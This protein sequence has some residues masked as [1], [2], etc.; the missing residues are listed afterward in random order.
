MI[1]DICPRRCHAERTDTSG[2]G[3]C[4]MALT[5]RIARAALHVW[6]EPCISGTRGSGAV[7]FSG[8]NLGCVFCQNFS[9]SH[10]GEGV[11][12]SPERLAG[13]FRELEAL[14]AHNINLVNPTHFV[15]AILKALSLYRPHLPIVYNC[16]GYESV[17]TLRSLEGIVD[18]YLPD[19]KYIDADAARVY[20]DAADYPSVCQA[21]LVE[22]C[23]QTGLPI[24]DD[25]G[26]MTR[27]TLVRHLVLPG[28]AGHSMRVLNWIEENLPKGTPVSLMGQYTPCGEAEKYPGMNRRLKKREYASVLAHMRAIGLT[29]GY[30]QEIAA[31]DRAF[32]PA[33]D[34]TGV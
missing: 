18:V 11:D 31:A 24:Y 1:C 20:S 9:I 2:A 26:L 34:G 16:G 25:S 3:R 4:R 10:G 12:V 17:Q 28:L 7:F 23:R 22:M 29:E 5:P 13:I 21:A 27:G 8:C 30:A 19:F 14:G 33:F 32:I 6:E 15:P